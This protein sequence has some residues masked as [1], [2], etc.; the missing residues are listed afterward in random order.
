[1]PS[2]PFA[3][4][5][6]PERGTMGC[7]TYS[8]YPAKAKPAH[9]QDNSAW[10][11]QTKD[12]TL[13]HK[14]LTV[15]GLRGIFATAL[16]SIALLGTV[17]TARAQAPAVPRN[18]AEFEKMLKITPAQKV[19]MEALKKKYDPKAKALQAQ[20]VSLQKQMQA[21]GAQANTEMQAVLTTEQKNKIKALQAA[22][23]KQMQGG[24][25]GMMAPPAGGASKM[26]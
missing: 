18:Q 10:V 9:A 25:G 5:N 16:V 14:K 20:M 17:G 3:C 12:I 6:K 23:M 19:K 26:R 22:Q 2:T 21:L 13:Y 1:M 11:A 8:S 7:I 15:P 4:A 24:G